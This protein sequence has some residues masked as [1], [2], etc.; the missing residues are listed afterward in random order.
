MDLLINGIVQLLTPKPFLLVLTGTFLGV[1]GGALPGI[2]GAMMIAL[3]LPMTFNMVP[4]NGLTLLIGM[5]V[6]AISGGLITATLMRMPGTPAAVMTTFD[7]YPMALGGRPG[8]A[9]GLG[10]TASFVGGMIA[11]VFLIV[12]SEPLADIATRFGPFEYFTLVLMALVL[13]ASVSEGSMI[14]GL[15]S[16]LL[17]MLFAMPG[18]DETAGGVPRI[19]FGLYYLN[20]GLGL[21]PVLIGVFC[22]SQLISDIVAIERRAEAAQISTKGIFMTLRD[23][24]NQAFNLVRSSLIGTWVGIL[25]GIGANIGSVISYTTAKNMSKTPEKF[26]SGSEEGVIASE[27]ANNATVGGALIP[28]IAMGIPGS[29]IDAVLIGA[30]MIHN[31]QPGPTLFINNPDLVYI[32]MAAYMMG[33]ILMFLIMMSS[34]GRISRLMFVPRAYLLP[35]IL[36]FCI[37]GSFAVNNTMFDVWVMLGFGV[38]GYFLERSDVPL[39]PFVIGFVLAPIAEAKLRSGLMMTAGDFKP[40]FLRPLCLIFVLISLVLLVWPIYKHV[41]ETRSKKSPALG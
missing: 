31:I 11:W 21:L 36:V 38:L 7:G 22:V 20:S 12:L 8:R 29:V 14:K 18:V 34:V 5:Y 19:T 40:I 3:T 35:P 39:G 15:L 28:L 41:R 23:W 9:L 37:I 25:P 1:I 24:K 33:N 17:G 27:A 13:I 26:G 30:L 4:A 32:M 16:G 10:I 2:T 6:G